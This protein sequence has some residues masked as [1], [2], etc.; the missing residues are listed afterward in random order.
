[1][2]RLAILETEEIAKELLF[3]LMK[4]LKDREWSFEY[5]TKISD[6][7]KSDAKNEFQIVVFHKKFDIPRITQTFVLAKQ[8]RIVLYT[9]DKL[10]DFTK[11]RHPYQR[12]LYVDKRHIK[13]EMR[14]LC[15][16]IDLLL[17]REEEYLFTYNNV[18]VP[19]KISDMIYIEKEDKFLVYHTKRGE[20]KERKNMKDAVAYFEAYDFI[21]IHVSYLVNMQYIMQIDFDH[22]YLQNKE[23]LPISRSK[24]KEVVERMHQI[25]NKR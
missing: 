24:R 12:I 18:S 3:E 2:I 15:P 25:V 20:F 13:E 9:E 10:N 7:A 22:L 11:V 4:G 19:L 21:W 14:L 16:L 5:F 8:R 23:I 6:F 17:K 1:M